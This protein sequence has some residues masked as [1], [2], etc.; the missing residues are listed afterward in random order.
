[1]SAGH[2]EFHATWLP[3]IQEAQRSYVTIC[4]GCTGGKHRSVFLA[5][6]LATS[7]GRNHENVLVH[8]RE[9]PSWN[10]T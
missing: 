6:R 2:R 8:H 1:M 9:K 7:L 10:N 3:A 5:E 4:I